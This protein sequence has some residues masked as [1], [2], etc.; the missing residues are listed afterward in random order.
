MKD[1]R[2]IQNKFRMILGE[3]SVE[4]LLGN[5]KLIEKATLIHKLFVE[6]ESRR[7]T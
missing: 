3:I 4:E 5:K 7:Q 1:I 2:K 6:L